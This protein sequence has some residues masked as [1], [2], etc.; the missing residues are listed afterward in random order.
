MVRWKE[1][2]EAVALLKRLLSSEGSRLVHDERLRK[3]VRKLE[4]IQKGGKVARKEDLAVIVNVIC[5]VL[6]EEVKRA[7]QERR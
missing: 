1:L 6:C 7:S 4:A 5:E 3:A 2:N